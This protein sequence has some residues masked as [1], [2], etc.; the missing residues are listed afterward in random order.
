MENVK[1]ILKFKYCLQ[2][3]QI[4]SPP[5]RPI[6]YTYNLYGVHRTA[7]LE[8]GERKKALYQFQT[9]NPK[10]WASEGKI[11]SGRGTLR[12]G[13]FKRLAEGFLKSDQKDKIMIYVRLT[14]GMDVPSK[15]KIIGAILFLV[16]YQLIFNSNYL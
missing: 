16:I 5:E 2:V 4:C 10:G 14:P 7:I 13:H 8:D 11:Y 9:D 12:I 6:A 3:A 15:V 1:W